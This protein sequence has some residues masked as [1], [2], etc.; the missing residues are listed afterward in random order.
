MAIMK[1]IS[2]KIFD[3]LTMK[4][5]DVLLE[6]IAHGLS[7]LCRGAGQIKFFYSVAQH[8]INCALEAKARGWSDRLVL[9]CLMHDASE[10]YINDIIRPVK[11]HLPDYRKIEDVVMDAILTRFGLTGLTREELEKCKLID[12]ELMNDELIAM[13]TGEE[14][15]IPSIMAIKPDMEEHLPREMEKKFLEVARGLL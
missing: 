11:V 9:L 14:E 10:A 13:F 6:D 12:N 7:L 3:P 2:G 4:P 15:R 1:T 5:E 8:S